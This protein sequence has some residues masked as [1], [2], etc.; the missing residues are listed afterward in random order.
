MPHFFFHVYNGHGHTPDEGG[1]D[2]EDQA[3]A[4][5]MALD[6]IRSM[7]AEEARGGVID[8]QGRIDVK[9]GNSNLLVTV[10]YSEAFDLRLPDGIGS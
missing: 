10:Y 4:H 6:S 5:R 2:M 9:D 7:V 3:A 8:L 1:S